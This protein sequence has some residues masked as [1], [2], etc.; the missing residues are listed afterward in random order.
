MLYGLG[1]LTKRQ[2]TGQEESE[3]KIL[4]FSLGWTWMDKFMNAIIRGT[5]QVEPLEDKV[6]EDRLHRDLDMCRG[7]AVGMFACL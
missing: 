1:T 4:R 2:K 7:G 3:M 5:V 6:R